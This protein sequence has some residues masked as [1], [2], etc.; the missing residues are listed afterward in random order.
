MNDVKINNDRTVTATVLGKWLGVSPSSVA[1]NARRGYVVRAPARGQYFLRESV[2][3]YASHLR[4]TASGRTDDPTTKEQVRLLSA[5]ADSAEAKARK[6]A[7]QYLG[8]DEVDN[9]WKSMNR[10]ILAVLGEIPAECAKR[11][12]HLMP[13][14]IGQ[15]KDEVELALQPLKDAK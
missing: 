12:P 2:R 13:R 7:A 9:T 5:R 10:R 6:L 1:D 4:E 15:I 3:A 14:D 11:L 8:R